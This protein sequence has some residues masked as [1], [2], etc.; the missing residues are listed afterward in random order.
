MSR[1]YRDWQEEFK[2]LLGAMYRGPLIEGDVIVSVVYRTPKGT[3]RGD[4]DNVLG[5]TLD[6]LQPFPLANDRQVVE[7]HGYVV[8]GDMEIDI[9]IEPKP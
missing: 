4:L 1:R 8:K 3:L 7:L 9:S 6:A 2:S 5:G